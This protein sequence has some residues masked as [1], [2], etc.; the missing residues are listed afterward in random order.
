MEALDLGNMFAD[1]FRICNQ[2]H[3]MFVRLMKFLSIDFFEDP[4]KNVYRTYNLYFKKFNKVPTDKLI[5]TSL[6]KEDPNVVDEIIRNIFTA[7]PIAPVEKEYIVDKVVTHSKWQHLKEALE[8][9]YSKVADGYSDDIYKEISTDITNSIKFGLD[10]NLGVDLYDI[11]ER[12][13]RISENLKD[14]IP[15]G[16]SFIDR[17]FSGGF[18]R[19][20]CYAIGGIAG[21][22]KSI[23][24]VN[25][26]ANLLKA[27]YNVIHY[28][29]EMSEE[30]LGLRY[31]AVISKIT[32]K[33]LGSVTP[34]SQQRL[35]DKYN[36]LKGITKTHLKLKEFPTSTASTLDL[37]AHLDE[38]QVFYD[39][40]PDVIIVDYGDIM[41]STRSGI[42]SLY[43]EQ[44]QIFRDLRALGIK[45]EAVLITAT[46]MN[47]DSFGEKGGTVDSPGMQHIA[48][49]IEKTRILDGLF[50]IQ[51]STND[52]GNN[53]IGLWIVKNRNGASNVNC[54]FNINYD[55]MTISDLPGSGSTTSTK[56][57]ISIDDLDD[58]EEDK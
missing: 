30:R 18:A 20:E 19:K 58:D 24:L 16:Y 21:L 13:K 36:F 26:G 57:T 27:G 44:G 40:K 9:G 55:T 23:W 8:N 4:Y 31:D 47:R 42:K 43:E 45:Q 56:T 28:S 39:F 15:T 5:R 51:Q 22:G 33:E 1:V 7:D 37:E 29:M 14:K 48:D 46:Q 11:T 50:T 34:E 38:L 49:S 3:A 41:K 25:I 53:Q 10:T 6:D 17:E 12:Y 35:H 52:K 54:K 32:T 2:D